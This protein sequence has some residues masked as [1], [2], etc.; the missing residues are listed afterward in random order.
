MFLQSRHSERVSQKNPR[1]KK[2]IKEEKEKKSGHQ[3]RVIKTWHIF[4]HGRD[5]SCQFLIKSIDVKRNLTLFLCA[6]RQERPKNIPRTTGLMEVTQCWIQQRC[7]L[8]PLATSLSVFTSIKW[9]QTSLLSAL[10]GY[11]AQAD[12]RLPSTSVTQ[13]IHSFPRGRKTPRRGWGRTRWSTYKNLSLCMYY[14]RVPKPG[15]E[16]GHTSPL[17]STG[18]INQVPCTIK[19]RGEAK[20]PSLRLTLPTREIPKACLIYIKYK[21][22]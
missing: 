15:K 13:Q 14:C 17:A 2:L 4:Q 18:Q 12:T 6:F 9:R 1:R 11:R 7:T 3:S 16:G 19:S 21:Y 10:H 8:R 5:L 20:F 22:M